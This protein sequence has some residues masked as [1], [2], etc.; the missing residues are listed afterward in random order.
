MGFLL[1]LRYISFA[2]F[3][4]VWFRFKEATAFDFAS[5]I[6]EVDEVCSDYQISWKWS[7]CL[8][9]DCRFWKKL[10]WVE[11]RN[12][13]GIN[14]WDASQVALCGD[15]VKKPE[16]E[17]S[18]ADQNHYFCRSLLPMPSWTNPVQDI[19]VGSMK[20]VLTAKWAKELLLVATGLSSDNKPLRVKVGHISVCD[21]TERD[22]SW[23][24]QD[25]MR[26]L[27]PLMLLL[28]FL[29]ANKS[30]ANHR[31][32]RVSDEMNILACDLARERLYLLLGLFM[33]RIWFGQHILCV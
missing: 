25:K 28:V 1:V 19:C 22:E 3:Y 30:E 12:E 29:F 17:A 2:S 15:V 21:D 5:N 33:M 18:E 13:V 11:G 24:K 26:L 10:L 23:P 14:I 9:L 8:Q 20:V 6:C 4:L 16:T 27:L 31:L 32:Q 7:Y